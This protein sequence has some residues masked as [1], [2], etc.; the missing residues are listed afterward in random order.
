MT[1]HALAVRATDC[2]VDPRGSAATLERILPF[3]TVTRAIATIDA[4]RILINAPAS[5]PQWL[6]A[7]EPGSRVDVRIDASAARSLP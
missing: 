2:R 5:A 3:G 6:T 1:R 4:T 7:L